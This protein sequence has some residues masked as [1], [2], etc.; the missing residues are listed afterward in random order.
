MAGLRGMAGRRDNRSTD[1]QECGIEMYRHLNGK[2]PYSGA[3][4][5]LDG[6]WALIQAGLNR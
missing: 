5:A 6:D 4:E 3:L 2:K 1:L